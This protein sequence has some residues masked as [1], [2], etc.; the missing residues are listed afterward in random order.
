MITKYRAD[1][2]HEL[3]SVKSIT[4]NSDRIVLYFGMAHLDN[5]TKLELDPI[6]RESDRNSPIFYCRKAIAPKPNLIEESA[7]RS[8]R[9]KTIPGL[10]QQQT[11]NSDRV[12]AIVINHVTVP[13]C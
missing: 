13:G 6:Y 2:P 4:I 8:P 7:G 12:S 9:E 10:S 1:Q 5:D 11:P 3:H